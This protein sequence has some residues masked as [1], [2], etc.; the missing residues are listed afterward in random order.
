MS[1]ENRYETGDGVCCRSHHASHG[2][3]AFTFNNC[4]KKREITV[5]S[6]F[7]SEIFF[8]LSSHSCY[9]LFPHD[10]LA[11]ENKI[12]GQD[13][14]AKE[15]SGKAK[16]VAIKSFEGSHKKKIILIG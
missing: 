1:T 14:K 11:K 6:R 3:N 10:I 9:G 13:K 2:L 5:A 8:L 12:M 7:V 4:M 16:P 15:L